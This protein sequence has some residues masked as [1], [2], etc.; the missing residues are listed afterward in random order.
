MIVCLGNWA[1]LKLSTGLTW[2]YYSKYSDNFHMYFFFHPITFKYPLL[3]FKASS[4]NNNPRNY[5]FC[6]SFCFLKTLAPFIFTT[7]NFTFCSLPH[8]IYTRTR[9]LGYFCFSYDYKILWVK[10]SIRK[11]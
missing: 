1:A 9:E 11:S 6:N 4:N 7:F 2:I 8:L 10:Y 3:F 5:Y